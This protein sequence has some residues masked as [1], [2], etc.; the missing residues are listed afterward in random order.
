[1]TGS[2]GS[3]GSTGSD[4]SAGSTGSTGSA[5]STGSAGSTGS[6]EL[7]G[8]TG[9]TDPEARNRKQL[10]QRYFKKFWEELLSKL[11]QF[12]QKTRNELTD[13]A[14]FQHD[15]GCMVKYLVF[16]DFSS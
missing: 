6:T 13:G 15:I 12:C 9:A 11:I 5:D 4:G 8:S 10:I 3:N 14:V 2:A 16:K 7:A 1:M